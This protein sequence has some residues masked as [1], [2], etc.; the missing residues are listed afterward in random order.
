MNSAENDLCEDDFL[1]SWA[2]LEDGVRAS[3]PTGG[4][5]D[6]KHEFKPMNT[7]ILLLFHSSYVDVNLPFQIKKKTVTVDYCNK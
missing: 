6:Y 5:P 7:N 4:R 1:T 2:T 3:R